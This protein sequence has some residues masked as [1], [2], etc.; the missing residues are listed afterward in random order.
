MVNDDIKQLCA[1]AV[2]QCATLGTPI[3]WPARGRNSPLPWLCAWAAWMADRDSTGDVGGAAVGLPEMIK[4][5]SAM[6]CLGDRIYETSPE[7]PLISRRV[8]LRFSRGVA[9]LSLRRTAAPQARQ[10]LHQF[11]G[12]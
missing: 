11:T 5:E 10:A 3:E 4:T 8:A 2:D 6:L 12:N 7:L 1:G 9:V